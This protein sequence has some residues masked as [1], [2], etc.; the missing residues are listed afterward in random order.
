MD[1]MDWIKPAL[2]ADRKVAVVG[3]VM[4]DRHAYCDV[5]GISPEDDLAPKVRVQKILQR[6]GG[7]GNVALN[8]AAMGVK[9]VYMFGIKGT[10]REIGLPEHMG[11]WIPR[12]LEHAGVNSRLV[13]DESRCPTVKTRYITKHGRH[14]CRVDSEATAAAPGRIREEMF[15]RMNTEGPFDLIVVSDYAKGTITP[16]VM[17]YLNR[18]GAPVIVDPKVRDFSVYGPVTALTPN[19]KEAEA[20]SV[21]RGDTVVFRGA[22]E[23]L[24]EHVIITRGHSGC[25]IYRKDASAGQY[26]PLGNHW[27]RAREVGD[28]T[29]CG[30]AFTA[31]LAVALLAG[32]GIREACRLGNL[33]GSC[34]Y[35]H[36]G[37]YSVTMADIQRELEATDRSVP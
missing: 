32:I 25:G 7:A 1:L 14:V 16:A 18:L 26:V 20:A 27:P 37:V 5:L 17:A 10:R 30:D 24:A 33:T 21:D 2:K 4:V 15:S 3:D 23:A 19:E 29:G 36:Q 31:G 8:L 9:N 13:N 12:M 34:A 35:D 11:N 28:P 22:F 6:P